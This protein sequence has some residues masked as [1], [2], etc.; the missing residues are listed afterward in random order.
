MSFLYKKLGPSVIGLTTEDNLLYTYN[1]QKQ[2]QVK[3]SKR[4]FV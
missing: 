2:Q 3:Q 4:E 1:Q